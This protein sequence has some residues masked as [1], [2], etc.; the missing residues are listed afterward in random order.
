[1][2]NI[3][4]KVLKDIT[5][6]KFQKLKDSYIYNQEKPRLFTDMTV[7]VVALVSRIDT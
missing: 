5:A 7:A 3:K 1:M 2:K 4:Q 6:T